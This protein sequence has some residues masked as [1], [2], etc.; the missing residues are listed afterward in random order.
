MGIYKAY[1]ILKVLRRPAL[2][3]SVSLCFPQVP[4]MCLPSESIF[5][6]YSLPLCRLLFGNAANL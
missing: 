3:K 2:N 4:Q 6:E 5:S 1:N